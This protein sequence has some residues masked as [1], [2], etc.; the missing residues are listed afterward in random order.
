YTTLLGIFTI[1]VLFVGSAMTRKLGWKKSALATPLTIGVIGFI[2][3]VCI[4]FP[5]A[6]APFA[7][8]FGVS[9]VMIGV[10]LGTVGNILN[11]SIKYSLF[12]PTKEMAY[13]PLDDESKSKGKA[14]VDVV[15]G[16]FGKSGGALLQQLM[17]IGIGPIGVIA[18]YAG[19][20]LM[21]IVAIWS[22]AVLKLSKEFSKLSQ[23]AN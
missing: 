2:F 21:A 10:V 17:I 6:V 3:F 20:C 16:R 18:P 7:A 4:I 9:T 19:V 8:L 5:T 1:V 15:G 14:A 13:I 23:E 12:D 11:K 22:L